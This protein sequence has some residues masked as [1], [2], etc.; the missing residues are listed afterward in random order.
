MSA[1]LFTSYNSFT[2]WSFAPISPLVV[3]GNTNSLMRKL[4]YLLRH[5]RTCEDKTL[6]FCAEIDCFHEQ[7]FFSV[8]L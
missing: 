4:C 5:A 1:K 8:K 6:P 7:T 2:V 3:Y